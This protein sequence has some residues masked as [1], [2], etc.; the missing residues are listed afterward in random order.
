MKNAF[1]TSVSITLFGE[2]HGSGIGAVLDGLAPGIPVRDD[3]ILHMLE[4][5]APRGNISTHRQES[6]R[7]RIVS[8]VYNGKT[9]GTPITIYIPNADTHSKDYDALQFCPRPGHADY[10]AFCKYH[11]F[12]DARGGGHFSGR[13]TAALVAAGAICQSALYEKGIRIGTHIKRCAKIDDRDFSDYAKDITLLNNLAFPVLDDN[14]GKQ[15]Q[16]AI[17][18]TRGDCNSVGG[19][20]ETVVVGFPAGV[21]EP[22]FD[23]AES[24]LSHI[25]FSIPAVKGVQFGDGFALAD[26]TGS[27]SNDPFRIDENGNIITATNRNGGINGGITNGMP[28]RFSCAIKPTPSISRT[29]DTVDLKQM[30]NTQI[31]I[32][33]RHDPAVVHRARAVVDASVSIALCDMLALRFGTDYLMP[34][35][36]P[37]KE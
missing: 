3:Y 9:T 26:M 8:G 7:Y 36:Q 32:H 1:G 34:D 37:E 29:Q 21:G 30:E 18:D 22:W 13:V 25:L 15:M 27:A 4:Q 6:D 5:R 24:V 23:T 10:T 11:G 31:T 28:L 16:Q 35:S 12:Q 19:I 2:S 14:A 20:L 33:G 17:L